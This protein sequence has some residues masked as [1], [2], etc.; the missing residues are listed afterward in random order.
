MKAKILLVEDEPG[1]AMIV[2]DLLDVE[3]YTVATANDGN[4]GLRQAID[5]P[6]DMLIL[7]VMLPGIGGFEICQSVRER[8]FTGAVLMLTARGQVADCVHGLEIGADDYLPKPFDPD[9]L[10]ARINALLRRVH[11][12]PLTPVTKVRFGKFAGDFASGKFFRNGEAIK[13]SGKEKDLLRFLVHQRGRILPRATILE[14]VWK[15]QSFITERT[16]DVH[17][18]WLRQKLGDDPQSPHYIVT[19][20]G[21]GYRFEM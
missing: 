2:A 4:A 19:V 1:V 16:V 3:G 7:D 8:G 5:E 18:S 11:Q 6:F 9:E 17:I 12:E 13:L 20:R 14:Q 15:G 21:E 10:L